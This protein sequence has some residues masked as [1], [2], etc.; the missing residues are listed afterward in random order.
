[1]PI[2]SGIYRGIDTQYGMKLADLFNP[3]SIAQRQAAADEQNMGNQLRQ[4]QVMQGVQQMNRAPVLAKREDL[5]YQ[6]EQ[7]AQARSLQDEQQIRQAVQSAG[8]DVSKVFQSL[9]QIGSPAAL[10]M[11]DKVKG[12]MSKP[13]EP[14]TIGMTRFDANNKPVAQ[15]VP[16]PETPAD[17]QRPGWQDAERFKAG[18]KPQ[19]GIDTA[20]TKLAREKFEW[21]KSGGKAPSK[22]LPPNVLK[23]QLEETDAIGTASG[24]NA[25]LGAIEK[26]LDSGK[27]KLSYAENLRSTLKNQ[28]LPF[29]SGSDENSRNFATFQS[30]LEKL[31]ND[32]L[33]LNKGVQTD[34]DAVRAWNELMANINDGGVV[35]QR[36]GEIR[37]LNARAVQLR[38]LNIDNIRAN[39]G[40]DPLDVTGYQNLAPAVATDRGQPGAHPADI[41]GLL[42]QY[43]R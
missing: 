3:A 14:Y 31:R 43:G 15:G 4:M 24:I 23:M 30:T 6:Q 34:G 21:E 29:V 32:S 41:N 25:D 2:D 9:I 1:M 7:G 40:H 19:T 28:N 18:L 10:T 37:N 38:K 39:Y 13:A 8:G 33:R 27:L 5:K 35:K 42:Q 20:A 26:Q 11:A 12:M 22:P 36:I 17:W 16:A